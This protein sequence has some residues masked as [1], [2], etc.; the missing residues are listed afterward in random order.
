MRVGRVGE[1]W[2]YPVKSMQGDRL[3]T[4]EIT[5]RWG[6]PG[7]RG[8]GL[9]DET[10]GEI[11]GAKRITSLLQFHARY[12][13]E[14]AGDSTPPVEITFPDG[15]VRRSDDD[16]IHAALSK[17]VGRDVT[18]WP[19][20]P[21]DDH[22]HYR[23][24]RTSKSEMLAQHDLGPNEEFPDFSALPEDVLAELSRFATPPGTYFDAMPL[25]LLTTA[26]LATVR[27]AAPDSAI[28][29]RRFRKNIILETDAGI[30]TASGGCPELDWVGR[31]LQIGEVECDVVMPIARCIMVGLPQAELP[32]DR[33]ILRALAT[34]TGMEL[35][36]YLRVV[37]PG[38]IC[39][40]DVV[41]L[42]EAGSAAERAPIAAPGAH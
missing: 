18:L 23:R 20:M 35:G 27:R 8:W 6:V 41:D 28:D 7:D 26:S 5:T 1:L 37:T 36:V 9:R 16:D 14:P 25:S 2:R 40:G 24:V 17:T 13:E 30:E 29:S 10:V 3:S 21:R 38:T 4:A 32:H 19:R 12:L 39:E 11:R 33:A 15:S 31:R 34:S 42:H 22:A